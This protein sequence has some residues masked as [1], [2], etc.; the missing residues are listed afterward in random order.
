MG[1]GARVTGSGE[2]RSDFRNARSQGCNR[3]ARGRDSPQS[4][5][6]SINDDLYHPRCGV[7]FAAGSLSAAISAFSIARLG[8]PHD[9]G[10]HRDT[11]INRA[12]A[13]IQ[14][15]DLAER[16]PGSDRC[17][18][19][20]DHVTAGSVVAGPARPATEPCAPKVGQPRS[21]GDKS[22]FRPG[23]LRAS[24]VLTSMTFTASSSR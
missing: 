6:S 12:P 13:R 10:G 5:R 1:C 3:L 24:R 2:Q 20:S 18:P 8:L 19:G 15:M 9:V 11:L 23:R 7:R 16:G 17:A 14:V 4:V 22:V 21:I